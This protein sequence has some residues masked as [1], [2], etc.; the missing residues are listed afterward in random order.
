[1][2]YRNK[3]LA[4]SAFE[5]LMEVHWKHVKSRFNAASRLISRINKKVCQ[6]TAM[7]AII[8]RAIQKMEE[9]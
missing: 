5:Q 8:Q 7:E 2:H 6:R 3:R 4:E 1:M 9:E